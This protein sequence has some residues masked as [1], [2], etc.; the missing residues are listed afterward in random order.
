MPDTPDERLAREPMAPRGGQA[1]SGD[2]GVPVHANGIIPQADVRLPGPTGG[3]WRGQVNCPY[4]TSL[5]ETTLIGLSTFLGPSLLQCRDCGRLLASHRREWGE[6]GSAGKAWYV[7]VSLVHVGF[8]AALAFGCTWL[9]CGAGRSTPMWLPVVASAVCGAAVG[10]LQLWRVAR[11]K[12]RTRAVDRRPHQ[13]GLWSLDFCLPQKVL[14][15]I[16]L[17]AFVLRWLAG[18][19]STP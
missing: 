17:S 13:P 16:I 10:S 3:F 15:G 5:I 8:C 6:R 18:F 7:A 2:A 9:A 4:C 1:R 12:R 19:A 11:S 14:V